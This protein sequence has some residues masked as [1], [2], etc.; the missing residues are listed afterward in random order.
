[1]KKETILGPTMTGPLLQAAGKN[2]AQ[3]FQTVYL[4]SAVL[5]AVIALATLVF[6]RL[7]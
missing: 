5:L 1:M 4:V 6:A 3:G 2:Q 7:E